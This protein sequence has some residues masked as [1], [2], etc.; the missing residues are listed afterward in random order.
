MD[1]S[2]IQRRVTD[3]EHVRDLET[4]PAEISSR[5]GRRASDLLSLKF[6]HVEYN[7]ALRPNYHQFLCLLV[8]SC[9]VFQ[10]TSSL[11]IEPRATCSGV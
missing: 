8:G 9:Y 7:N 3:T 11:R 6:S 10:V 5:A 4:M 1:I 2:Y